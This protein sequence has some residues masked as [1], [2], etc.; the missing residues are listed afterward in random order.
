M[1]LACYRMRSQGNVSANRENIY[2][3][4]AFINASAD[5]RTFC[6]DG[7]R[8]NLS[9]TCKDLVI[10]KNSTRLAFESATVSEEDTTKQTLRWI[11][12]EGPSKSDKNIIAAQ[13]IIEEKAFS[14]VTPYKNADAPQ[15]RLFTTTETVDLPLTKR[16]HIDGGEYNFIWGKN[17]NRI[18]F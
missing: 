10:N 12:K 7:L 9:Y 5:H 13:I 11:R 17:E 2:S 6:F 1:G 8:G 18:Q 16:W 14:R 4:S 15:L 3:A